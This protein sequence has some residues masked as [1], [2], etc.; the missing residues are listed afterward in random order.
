MSRLAQRVAL[1]S[2]AVLAIQFLGALGIQFVLA[3][4]L[5]AEILGQLTRGMEDSGALRDCTARPGPWRNS[6]GW[7][8]VWPL[9]A[10]GVPV[11]EGAGPA[12]VALPP[13]G[14]SRPWFAEGQEGVIYAS[15]SPG[16]GGILLV[17]HTAFPVLEAR[18]TQIATL[19]VLRLL[20]ILLAAIAL[21]AVTAMP[22]VRRI[23]ALSA[24]MGASSP[25]TSTG[26]W[27][28]TPTTSLARW[29]GPS[30]PLRPRPPSGSGVSN[31]ATRSFSALWRTSPTT[32]ARRWRRS[33]SRRRA[34]RPR[35]RR[36]RSALSSTTSSG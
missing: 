13:P 2:L 3:R 31:I 26:P 14:E 7:W 23:R 4:T 12:R 34:S 27:P 30:T 19:V 36:A 24:A 5:R 28:M 32:S 35:P 22:L 10:E 11:G 18:S 21:V 16:C 1:A 20:L 8:T 6:R 9:T 15:P 29:P 33:S 25:T 17:E